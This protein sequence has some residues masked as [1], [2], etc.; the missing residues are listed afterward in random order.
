MPSILLEGNQHPTQEG[1]RDDVIP[2]QFTPTPLLCHVAWRCR[3]Q[4]VQCGYAR[5][6]VLDL[7]PNG[8]GFLQIGLSKKDLEQDVV[9]VL[10]D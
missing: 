7:V 5:K 4:R 10:F 1:G 8:E 2:Y 6:D 9:C 3:K